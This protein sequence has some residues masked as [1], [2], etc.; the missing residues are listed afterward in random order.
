MEHFQGADRLC[1]SVSLLQ[2]VPST[3]LKHILSL[4]Q[5]LA[6]RKSMLLVQ[7]NQVREMSL[8]EEMGFA[9]WEEE[10]SLAAARSHFLQPWVKSRSVAHPGD[11]PLP[12]VFSRLAPVLE[13][14]WWP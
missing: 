13:A 6:A 11:N 14:V 5:V 10:G 4:W 9:P 1:F 7:M 12:W 3:K 2:V 8:G